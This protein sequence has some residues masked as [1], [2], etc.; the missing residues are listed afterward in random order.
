MDINK[1]KQIVKDSKDILDLSNQ[2]L[3]DL[4]IETLK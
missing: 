3:I 4:D 1:L 2:Q